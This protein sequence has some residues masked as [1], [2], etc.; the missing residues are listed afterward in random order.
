[1]RR[2]FRPNAYWRRFNPLE[3]IYE[4]AGRGTL[5][6]GGACHIDLAPWATQ[7]TW[8]GLT[9]TEQDALLK[10]SETT[11][12]SLVSSARFEVLLLNGVRVVEGLERASP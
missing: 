3:S 8:S 5:R 2:L 4:A 9:D 10:Y 12:T 7:L 11:L 6:D 1:M